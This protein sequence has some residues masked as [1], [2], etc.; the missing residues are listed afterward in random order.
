[1]TSK[2][3]TRSKPIDTHNSRPSSDK[4]TKHHLF[5][6]NKSDFFEVE[7]RSPVFA[8]EQAQAAQMLV[9]LEPVRLTTV[10]V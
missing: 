3:E 2:S 9:I 7:N 4:N 6:A 8:V 5:L 1:M 10:H